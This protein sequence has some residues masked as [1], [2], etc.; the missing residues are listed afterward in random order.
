MKH[1]L[2]NI[3]GPKIREIRLKSGETQA[4]FAKKLKIS[5]S[6][7]AGL[8]QGKYVTLDVVEKICDIYNVSLPGLL[9]IVIKELEK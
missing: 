6:M 1:Q 5:Q 3:I 9:K 2:A 8:E 7:V 4:R